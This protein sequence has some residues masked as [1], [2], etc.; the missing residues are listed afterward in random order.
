MQSACP[1]TMLTAETFM[2]LIECEIE[3]R[4]RELQG[5]LN[6]LDAKVIGVTALY[7][8]TLEEVQ[9]YVYIFDLVVYF[10]CDQKRAEKKADINF[11][12]SR[13]SGSFRKH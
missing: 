4:I 3:S 1:L 13:T 10:K 8:T 12:L 5:V 7:G 6:Q 11:F 9:R 2:D